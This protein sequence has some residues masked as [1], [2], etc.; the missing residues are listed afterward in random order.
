[1]N[2]HETPLTEGI[3]R[4]GLI[5]LD[6]LSFNTKFWERDASLWKKDKESQDFIV[7][8]LG[9]QKVYDWTLDHLE[10][11]L[12]F[13]K[14]VKEN[15]KHCVVMGMGGSSL[16]PE[17]FRTVFGKQDGYPELIVLDTTN[18]DWVSAARARINPAQTLFIFASKS[19]GTVEPSSQFA[20]FFDEVKKSGVKEPGQNFAAIT[21][22]STGLEALAKQHKFRH[23]FI[24]PSDIGGRFSALSFFGIVPAAI[25]GV[26]V[27]KILTLA[28]EQAASFGPQAPLKENAAL[29]LGA[30]MG[31]CNV[32][33]GR[34]KL[35]LLTPKDLATFGL[36]AEQLVAES[37]GKE[38]KGVVP[39]AGETLQANFDYREDRFFVH[40]STGSEDDK[41]LSELAAQLDEHEVPLLTIEINSLYELGALF[42]LWEIAT[43]AA[44]AIL[45]INPFDQP[46]V[47][48]AKT[49]TK[50]VLA[51]LAKGDIPA[52]ITAPILVSKDIAD[53]VKLETLAQD[54]YSLL[55]SNDYV[56]LLPYVYP[57]PDTERALTTLREKIMQRTKRAVLFGY[58]PR[59]LHYTGQLHKGDGNNGVF[60]IFS[61][62]PENDIQ[63]PGQHYSFGQLCNAQALGDFQALESKGRR[64]IKL[65]LKQPLAENIRKI[66]DLF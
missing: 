19:G 7:Q 49:M 62:E 5:K 63:I 66:S 26:D 8:F 17:V 42:L 31:A 55:E 2:T 21:D 3:I 6:S 22:K 11:V 59:Y 44:G 34:D 41:R 39:V 48:E 32:N 61:A 51:K 9:W 24:N 30:L 35:T 38:G 47:Q 64:V 56:A 10:E 52:E 1:M 45:A 20:Y 36:W 33:H 40:L 37:T 13:A 43:A 46:N 12:N 27:K 18:P 60:I 23:T 54:V 4:E 16:A 29:K 14:D 53:E 50:E 28:K 25:M 58:G 57:S 15:F 65:H